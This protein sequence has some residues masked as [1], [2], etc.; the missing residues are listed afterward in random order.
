MLLPGQLHSKATATNRSRLDLFLP[1]LIC[2]VVLIEISSCSECLIEKNMHQCVVLKQ[3]LYHLLFK[4]D[5]ASKY[6][7]H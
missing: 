1:L 4:S 6:Q 7:A 5:Y 2:F 3:I